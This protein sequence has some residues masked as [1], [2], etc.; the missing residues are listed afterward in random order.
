MKKMDHFGAALKQLQMYSTMRRVKNKIVQPSILRHKRL[1]M[2]FFSQFIKHGD[3]C[4]DVGANVGKFT[5]VFLAIGAKVVCVE[6]Q[7]ACLQELYKL[8]GNKKD[9]FI[10]GK[11]V[12]EYDGY[13]EIMICENAPT[14]ST[15]YN[16]WRNE[17]RFS[18][19]YKWTRTQT[20]PVTTLDTLIRTYGLP[21]FCKIDVEGF[22]LPV[23]KGLSKPI[24]LI[25]FEFHRE[26]FDD[27]RKCITHLSTLG[28]AKFNCV[29]GESMKLLFKKWVTQ[30]EL[31]ERIAKLDDKL[32]WGDIYAKF[33]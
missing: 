24:H 8:F 19:D 18:K 29:L 5:S 2:Q 32:L 22:E 13:G 10:V 20:V 7:E 25:S 30:N 4:F 16:R 27:S 21:K 17:S 15:M 6:P 33:L 1:M 31:C 23:L 3:L 9:V 28:P 11:A 26:F 12:G 14:I